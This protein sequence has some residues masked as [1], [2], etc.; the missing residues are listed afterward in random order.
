MT[1]KTVTEYEV[2]VDEKLEEITSFVKALRE[3]HVGVAAITHSITNTVKAWK[4]MD[5]GGMLQY[6]ESTLDLIAHHKFMLEFITMK[7]V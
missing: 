4:A 6:A 1:T 5:S 2:L 7:E 3:E